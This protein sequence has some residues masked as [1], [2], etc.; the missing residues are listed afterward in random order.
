MMESNQS[1]LS[2]KSQRPILRFVLENSKFIVPP[3]VLILVTVIVVLFFT[4]NKPQT[5]PKR[6]NLTPPLTVSVV[7]IAPQQFQVSVDSYGT[8][9]PRTQSFLVSQVSGQVTFVS[10]KLR[11]GSFF[12]KGD[13]LLKI[14][15]RDYLADVEISKANLA[16]AKQALAEELAL[17]S[18]AELD[19][20]NLGNTSEPN[21]LVLRKP[22]QQAARAR[23]ASAQAAL[24]KTEL[25]LE[26]TQIV[27]PYAGRVLRKLVDVGQV[28]NANTQVGEVY[29]TDLLELRLP[30][31]ASDLRFVDLP[32]AYRDTSEESPGTPVHIYSSLTDSPKPWIGRV[33]RTE[34]AIDENARQLHVVAQIDDPFSVDV[35]DRPQLKIGEYVTAKITGK[36][37]EDAIVIPSESVYQS[38]YVYVVNDNAIVRREVAIAWQSDDQ[39]LVSS[40]L[41]FGDRLVVTTLGQVASGSRVQIEGEAKPRQN[42]GKGN[43]KG[44]GKGKRGGKGKPKQQQES[45]RG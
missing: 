23:L 9:S 14:D 7:D 40:G 13:V 10:D 18:Q 33:V 35:V 20:K 15:D 32:E 6:N 41:E 21:D 38:S 34:S 27:A 17:A 26:R 5:K 25:T 22:Q 24:S 31:R 30:L 4:T 3:A 29:A 39:S 8:I 37:I 43:R 11:E 42:A 19:W 12:D 45:Q 16:D 2:S 44:E 28:T 1:T 36:V